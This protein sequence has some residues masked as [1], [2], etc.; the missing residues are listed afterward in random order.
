M[1]YLLADFENDLLKKIGKLLYDCDWLTTR[2]TDTI[3]R[4]CGVIPC[5]TE[6]AWRA[7]TFL[8]RKSSS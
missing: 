2:Q 1:E 4:C 8:C 6:S 5:F 7:T 3:H